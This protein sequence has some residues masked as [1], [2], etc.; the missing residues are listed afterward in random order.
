MR[1]HRFWRRSPRK[2]RS[3]EHSEKEDFGSLSWMRALDPAQRAVMSYR[4]NTAQ[5]AGTNSR[6]EKAPAILSRRRCPQAR[7]HGVMNAKATLAPLSGL[8]LGAVPARPA[9]RIAASQC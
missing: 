4:V 2:T 3:A 9:S 7:Y 1:R 6:P 8:I 5:P